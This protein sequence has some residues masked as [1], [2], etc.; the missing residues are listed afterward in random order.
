MNITHVALVFMTP[1]ALGAN[2]VVQG[3]PQTSILA[4][5]HA[6]LVGVAA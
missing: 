6:D 2:L 1:V 5:D 3:S 4:L